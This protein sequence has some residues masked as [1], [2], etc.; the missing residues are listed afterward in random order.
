MDSSSRPR[1]T[2]LSQTNDN[3]PSPSEQEA[4]N[5][6]VGHNT[7]RQEIRESPSLSHIPETPD[8][9]I[10]EQKTTQKTFSNVTKTQAKSYISSVWHWTKSL[11]NNKTVRRTEG[12]EYIPQG[13]AIEERNKERKSTFVSLL[14]S[15]VKIA[16]KTANWLSGGK[17]Q[18]KAL[19][20][21]ALGTRKLLDQK[22]YMRFPGLTDEQF[23]KLLSQLTT[24]VSNTVPE[25]S[26]PIDIIISEI[27]V[28][29][30]LHKPLKI[31]DLSFQAVPKTLARNCALIHH[32]GLKRSVELK[33]LE[34]FLD[35]PNQEENKPYARIF[36]GMKQGTFT[37]GSDFPSTLRKAGLMNLTKAAAW[38]GFENL[39]LDK[40]NTTIRLE[41]PE[42][43]IRH[44]RLDLAIPF[45]EGELVAAEQPGFM[46]FDEGEAILKDVCITKPIE[47]SAP[48]HQ[49]TIIQ[50]GGFAFK[51]KSNRKCLID[52]KEV[53]APNLDDSFSG[54]VSA[55]LSLDLGLARNLPDTPD[56][57]KLLNGVRLNCEVNLDLVNG[58]GDFNAI[59]KSLKVSEEKSWNP[60]SWFVAW[61]V[62]SVLKSDKT[63]IYKDEAG[64]H[65]LEVGF[66]IP[67]IGWLA[68]KLLGRYLKDIPLPGD[69]LVAR[70]GCKGKII[71]SNFPSLLNSILLT[72]IK[73]HIVRK[74]LE[75]LCNK[76]ACGDFSASCELMSSASRLQNQGH[77]AQVLR[78]LEAV[79]LEH[80]HKLYTQSEDFTVE[81]LS[82]VARR[83]AEIN[84]DKA[85]AV[86][87][88]TTNAALLNH[89]PDIENIKT[90]VDRAL[91]LCRKRGTEQT[92]AQDML[93]FMARAKPESGAVEHLATLTREKLY[94]A[95]QMARLLQRV[96]RSPHYISKP[97][98]QINFLLGLEP[99]I[100]EFLPQIL[101]Q[102][103]IQQIERD[104]LRGVPTDEQHLSV[105]EGLALKHHCP[106]T[107]V[108]WLDRLGHTTRAE[109]LLHSAIENGDVSALRHR[110]LGEIEHERYG[111][112]LYSHAFNLLNRLL[113]DNQCSSELQNEAI[114]LMS[115]L[116]QKTRNKDI[117]W[118]FLAANQNNANTPALS[119][120][121]NAF[122]K[123]FAIPT[124]ILTRPETLLRKLDE[125]KTELSAA[126]N[127]TSATSSIAT[128]SIKNCI[129][130]VDAL[131]DETHQGIQFQK[132]VNDTYQ[133]FGNGNND[134]AQ[135]QMSDLSEQETS[136]N[137]AEDIFSE[138][139]D[140]FYDAQE[141]ISDVLQ[142]NES[143]DHES[144]RGNWATDLT[145]MIRNATSQHGKD[146]ID[147]QRPEDEE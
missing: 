79:P 12:Q 69:Y 98:Q 78:I 83:L 27:E 82:H 5:P 22:L 130:V 46:A 128:L 21:G 77:S 38:S 30:G 67:V 63:Q 136:F 59:K 81:Q 68:G 112:P 6:T 28:D 57:L 94:P 58:E 25:S 42:L 89:L 121:K 1:R 54:H 33:N 132:L 125:I 133:Y 44:S 7:L 134:P 122:E 66:S 126:L 100:S 103:P 56:A 108:K 93:E 120:Q 64:N 9:Q 75:V 26:N 74:D 92:A 144:K 37:I 51:N 47:L 4:D 39:S 29:I 41:A 146:L 3:L 71:A 107:I 13:E 138:D 50:C 113:A 35:L 60:K 61:F 40:D 8:T 90:M 88:M 20:W 147:L 23:E 91:S 102:F 106:V 14:K 2:D 18:S 127:D 114:K 119:D 17:L 116:W 135:I 85:I 53:H 49:S 70:E 97:E 124:S 111:K 16:A 87:A 11:F 109:Q 118:P 62:N 72:P 139:E 10:H 99:E 76:A 48:T 101:E 123:L 65:K 129:R 115:Q 137:D 95:D 36:F 143:N 104:Y 96:I 117:D 86:Y 31:R 140:I 15:T 45:I 52:L 110:I 105:L 32:Q 73:A 55:S 24:L 142:L 145:S 19:N 43:I 84:P 141:N 34:C 80:I 131:A